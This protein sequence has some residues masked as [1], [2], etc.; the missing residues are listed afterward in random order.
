ME[1]AVIIATAIQFLAVKY[2]VTVAIVSAIGMA[3]LFMKPVFTFL[4]AIVDITPSKKDNELLGKAEAS[5]A[6]KVIT[7]VLDLFASVKLPK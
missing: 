2:P 5:Q 4:H 1:I 3:R 6:Y 7:F